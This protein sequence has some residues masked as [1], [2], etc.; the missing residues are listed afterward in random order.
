M[1]LAG[2]LSSS[3]LRAAFQIESP[4]RRLTLTCVPKTSD[5]PLNHRP[6]KLS[7]QADEGHA[8]RFK[9][10][11]RVDEMLQRPGETIQ[12]PDEDPIE[13]A[14]VRVCHQTVEGWA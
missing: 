9:F 12:F 14:S 5:A 4:E 13:M 6:F 7:P 8:E 11:E 2:T 1:E 3:P 10:C